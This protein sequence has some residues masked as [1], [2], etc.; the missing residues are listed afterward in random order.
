MAPA[1]TISNVECDKDI[2]KTDA[3]KLTP[4]KAELKHL[5]RKRNEKQQWYYVETVDNEPPA[6]QDDW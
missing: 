3:A 6:E 4:M 1:L 2:Q 5:D